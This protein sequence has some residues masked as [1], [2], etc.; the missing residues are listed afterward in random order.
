MACLVWPSLRR[1]SRKSPSGLWVWLGLTWSQ[2]GTH[3]GVTSSS[4]PLDPGKPMNRRLI[5]LDAVDLA[6]R[7]RTGWGIAGWEPHSSGLAFFYKKAHHTA[8][9]AEPSVGL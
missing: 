3:I 2:V 1:E 9:Q 8:C 6:S 5:F 4:C 7:C